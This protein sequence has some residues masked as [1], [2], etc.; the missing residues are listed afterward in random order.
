MNLKKAVKYGCVTTLLL[1]ASALAF[2]FNPLQASE[3]Q[4][5]ANTQESSTI[6]TR[7]AEQCKNINNKK[8]PKELSLDKEKNDA[9][10]DIQQSSN[11]AK[12]NISLKP[13][14]KHTKVRCVVV[15]NPTC[16]KSGV[17]LCSSFKA[18]II[19]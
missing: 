8:R 7:T 2:Y 15:K 12:Q 19:L 9:S 4:M 13:V 10:T 6:T 17:P 3:P 1:G 11:T 16:E 14:D 5:L 18:E